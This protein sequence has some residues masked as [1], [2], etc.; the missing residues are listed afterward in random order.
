MVKVSV[1]RF[2]LRRIEKTRKEIDTVT[3][4]L[5]NKTLKN[6]EEI[7]NSA[8][9]IAKGQIKRQRINRRMVPVTLGQR[10]RWLLV[11]GH[12]AMI[13]KKMSNNFDE[14]ETKLQ[15]D[16]LERLVREANSTGT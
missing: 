3:Q 8:S 1:N 7:F 15:L 13:M 10:R 5:R 4:R 2:V 16:K 14:K 11:A 12:A 9:R 6:L